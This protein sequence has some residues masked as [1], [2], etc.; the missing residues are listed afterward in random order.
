M[1]IMT[2]IFYQP[3]VNVLF[4]LA[5]FV[6][7]HSLSWAIVVLTVLIRLALLPS[8]LKTLEHQRRIQLLQPKIDE[9]KKKHAEDKNAL[10]KATIELYNAEKVSPFAS[11][12]PLIVQL[13]ILIALNSVMRH[14]LDPA[15][16]GETLALLYSFVPQLPSYHASFFGYDLAK[17]EPIVL[18]ILVGVISYIQVKQSMKL[19]PQSNRPDSELTNEERITK[20]MTK[21]MQYLFPVIFAISLRQQ[22]AA[23]AFYWGLSGLLTIA[24]Q[25]WYF[26]YKGDSLPKSVK[27]KSGVEV[28]VRQVVK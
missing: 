17:P 18:P 2:V 24:Q 3:L 26:K 10:N 23:L 9:I 14:G 19:Q 11:C 13:V 5:Y 27:T 21:N 8:S 16:L 22:P 15:K 6:P 28:S 20:S 12:L 7:G 4:L 1:N 25:A